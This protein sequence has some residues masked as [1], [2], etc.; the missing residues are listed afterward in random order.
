M[1]AI[2]A[3]YMTNDALPLMPVVSCRGAVYFANDY[4]LAGMRGRF[5][6]S[7]VKPVV[8]RTVRFVSVCMMCSVFAFMFMCT[9]RHCAGGQCQQGQGA[10]DADVIHGV[11]LRLLWVRPQHTVARL[12]GT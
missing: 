3:M 5:P 2:R 4:P 10:Q 9:C 8:L 1:A 6:P 12:N 11:R 7:L